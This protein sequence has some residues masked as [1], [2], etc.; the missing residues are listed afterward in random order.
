MLAMDLVAYFYASNS[1]YNG[2]PW[3]FVF[4]LSVRTDVPAE[5]FSDQLAVDFSSC[6]VLR[7]NADWKSINENYIK[8]VNFKRIKQ[9]CSQD[10]L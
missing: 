1:L 4:D 6:S 3:H 8:S 2:R 10:Q 9:C 5:A 7:Q